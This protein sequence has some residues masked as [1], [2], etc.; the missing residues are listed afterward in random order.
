[1]LQV[2]V[3]LPSSV[4]T[5]IVV[6]PAFKAVTLPSTTVATDVLLLFHD[7][8]LLVALSGLTVAVKVI[9]SPSV[10][11]AVVLSNDTLVTGYTF[12]TTVTLQ[13]AVL[14]PS[15]VFAVMVAVPGAIAVTTP[16]LTDATEELLEIH[17]IV[18]FSASEGEIV[19]VIV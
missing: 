3:L 5:V 8:F 2:A 12:A 10:N 9:V 11:E 17:R 14:A 18:L 15:S 1:M 7:T 4:V 19:A 16:P 13:V 6:V